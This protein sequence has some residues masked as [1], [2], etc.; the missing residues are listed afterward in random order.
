MSQ[1]GEL[2]FVLFLSD[3]ICPRTKHILSLAACWALGR[4]QSSKVTRQTRTPAFSAMPFELL[5]CWSLNQ[6]LGN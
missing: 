2:A 4:C 5:Q 6:S 1:V 3:S